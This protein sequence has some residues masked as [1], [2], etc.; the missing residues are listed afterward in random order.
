MAFEPNPL[1]YRRLGGGGLSCKI[2]ALVTVD[3]L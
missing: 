1:F 2:R 3:E